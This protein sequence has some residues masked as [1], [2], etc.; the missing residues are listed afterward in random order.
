M[1]KLVANPA[2]D[3]ALWEWVFQYPDG[4]VVP[5]PGGARYATPEDCAANRNPVPPF[6]EVDEKEKQDATS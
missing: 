4:R 1:K 3:A 6:I 5:L 2:W